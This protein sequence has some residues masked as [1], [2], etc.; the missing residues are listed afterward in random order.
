MSGVEANQSS[1]LLIVILSHWPTQM[2]LFTVL[3][4]LLYPIIPLEVFEVPIRCV[5][6]YHS[7]FFPAERQYWIVII[8]FPCP[9]FD[10]IDPCSPRPLSTVT[11]LNSKPKSF[12]TLLFYLPLYLISLLEYILYMVFT[13][14]PLSVKIF[15][16]TGTAEANRSAC[17]HAAA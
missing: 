5:V 1:Y 7:P 17:H 12:L 16:S 14:S 13:T 6:H 10:I 11:T 3:A 9:V 15:S 2:P 8:C 4:C